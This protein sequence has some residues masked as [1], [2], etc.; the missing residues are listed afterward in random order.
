[1]EFFSLNSPQILT[2]CLNHE[3]NLITESS[4]LTTL[5][6]K[7]IWPFDSKIFIKES[8]KNSTSTKHLNFSISQQEMGKKLLSLRSQSLNSEIIHSYFKL[9]ENVSENC[10]VYFWFFFGLILV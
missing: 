5:R 9:Y 8:L 2:L 4:N 1:M 10:K 6:I 7:L 3:T